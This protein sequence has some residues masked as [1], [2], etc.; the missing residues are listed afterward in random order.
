MSIMIA[1]EIDRVIGDGIGLFIKYMNIR[2][3][4]DNYNF[5]KI[6]MM[7]RKIRLRESGFYRYGRVI[8]R[9]KIYIM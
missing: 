7:F 8:R 5:M 1:Y 2:V 6:M 4:F 3:M 9:K